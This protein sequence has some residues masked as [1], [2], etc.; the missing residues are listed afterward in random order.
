MKQ[1]T[2]N[3]LK[4]MYIEARKVGRG[5]EAMGGDGYGGGIASAVEMS[6]ISAVLNILVSEYGEQK[7]QGFLKRWDEMA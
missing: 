6:Y 2:V 1:E 7:A 4:D 3:K 5:R